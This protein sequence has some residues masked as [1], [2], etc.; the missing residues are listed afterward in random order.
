MTDADESP[1][2]ADDAAGVET[3]HKDVCIVTGSSSGIGQATA[4]RFLAEDWVVY[5]TAR[6][7]A[8]VADLADAGCRTAELDVTDGEQVEAVVDRVIDEQGQVDCVVNNAGFAQFGPL[9][10]VT[11]ES[12]ERQFDVNA[13]GPHRLARAVLPHMRE[14]CDGTIV[15]V[16]SVVGELSLPG[17][18][19]YAGSKAA[20]ES[21]SDA[22]RAEVEEFG[23]DVVVVAPGPVD[24][25]FY[26]RA[27]DELASTA[28]RSGAYEDIYEL[29]DDAASMGGFGPASIGPTVVA[30][31]IVNAASATDPAPR[32]PVGPVAKYAGLAQFVPKRV[33]D[34]LFSLA[35]RLFA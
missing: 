14:A 20:V 9:E 26:D 17:S 1:A 33:R 28:Q 2:T 7:E 6:D 21:M 31:A 16:S 4:A 11:T 12:V 27:D 15:N 34:R 13:F 25:E 23:V 22:L 19:A 29:Y 32:Y 10:D 18:G 8:D 5:A 35:R 30:D 3:R 24:S